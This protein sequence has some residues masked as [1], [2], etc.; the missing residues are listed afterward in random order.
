MQHRIR[1]L[2]KQKGWT[3]KEVAR[4][5][6]TSEATI[7]R[8]ETQR[9][10]VS[11]SWLERLAAVFEVD[12]TQLIETGRRRVCAFEGSVSEDGILDRLRD[13]YFDL[14][15]PA[16]SGSV[17]IVLEF[18]A[19][20]FAAGDYIIG[21]KLSDTDYS[22][23]AGQ[24]CFGATSKAEM[25]IGKIVAA[26][27]GAGKYSSFMTALNGAAKLVPISEFAWIARICRRISYFDDCA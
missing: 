11:T 22:R 18:D 19:P 8:L 16:A 10:S 20:P 26:D 21:Q 24:Y 17:A 25:L 23:A 6:G 5:A 4:R 1:E 27:T 3:I 2:R 14:D 13:S 9:M 12:P 7:S 15:A